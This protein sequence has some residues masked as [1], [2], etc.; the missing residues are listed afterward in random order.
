MIHLIYVVKGSGESAKD[1]IE[2]KL[3]KLSILDPSRKE[4]RSLFSHYNEDIIIIREVG[5]TSIEYHTEGI[6]KIEKA[7]VD[8]Y[9]ETTRKRIPFEFSELAHILRNTLPRIKMNYTR[10][11]RAASRRNVRS[12]FIIILDALEIRLAHKNITTNEFVKKVIRL[13]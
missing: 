13:F 3:M 9:F 8:L 7:I 1:L 2:K 10:L 6:A 12:E 4:I 11:L 5:E